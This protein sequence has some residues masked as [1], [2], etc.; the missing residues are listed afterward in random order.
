VAREQVF[1]RGSIS[2]GVNGDDIAT[3]IEARCPLKGAV[4]ILAARR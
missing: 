4:L 2:E 1:A 3:G